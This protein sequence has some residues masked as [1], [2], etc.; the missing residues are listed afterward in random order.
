MV[1]TKGRQGVELTIWEDGVPLFGD[2]NP[3]NSLQCRMSTLITPRKEA[4]IKM[5]FLQGRAH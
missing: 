5:H 4:T 1:R 2:E 3:I